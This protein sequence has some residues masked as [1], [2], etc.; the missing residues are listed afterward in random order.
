MRRLSHRTRASFINE[1]GFQGFLM[2]S[3]I[4]EDIKEAEENRELEKLKQEVHIDMDSLL[5]QLK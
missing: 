3:S 2:L 5:R 4:S 1:K